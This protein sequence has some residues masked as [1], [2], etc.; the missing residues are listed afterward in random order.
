MIQQKMVIGEMESP[1]QK[2]NNVP[3][4]KKRAFILIG[5]VLV[6]AVILIHNLRQYKDYTEKSAIQRGDATETEYLGFQ[7]NLLKYS[8]D[9][10]FY[11]KYS[12]ELIWNYTY[13]M[14]DPQI[15][16][17]DSY[18]LIYDRKGTQI[19]ILTNTGFKQSIKTSMPIVDANIASQ[20]T[21]AVLMQEEDTGYVQL[22]NDKGE[23]LASGELHMDNNGYP[24]SL[25]ISQ[26]GEKMVVSQLDL[27]GGDVKTTIAFYNFG[28][29]GKD[30]IDNIVANYSFSNQIFPQVEFLENGKTVAFGDKEIVIFEDNAKASISKEIFVDGQIKSVFCNGKYF[31]TI[32]DVTD[33]EGKLNHLLNVYSGNGFPRS[34][35]KVSGNYSRVEMLPNNEV[36]LSDGEKVNIYTLYGVKK[37]AYTF[38]SGIYKIIPGDSAKRYYLVLDNRIADVRIK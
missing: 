22:F 31:G 34:E 13:E 4:G 38:D 8:R 37:F 28:K 32:C 14:A 27:N 11:T 3:P 2:K 7:G 19:A 1:Q 26:S 15:D 35:R 21:V 36:F 16:V 9:G 17:C 18:I 10:A 25:D 6:L 33:D 24:L 29:E 5:A 30:K 23:L 20:G 12:G